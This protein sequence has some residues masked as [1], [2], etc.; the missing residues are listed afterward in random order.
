MLARDRFVLGQIKASNLPAIMT[1]GGGYADPIDD[2]VAAHVGTYRVAAE[3]FGTCPRG[4][5]AA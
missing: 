2:S 1:L 4:Q 5:G 3:L